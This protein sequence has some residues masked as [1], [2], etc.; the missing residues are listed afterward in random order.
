[1]QESFMREK[2]LLFAAI[3]NKW[4]ISSTLHNDVLWTNFLRFTF[5]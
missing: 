3:A 1:M 5:N 2:N 4:K